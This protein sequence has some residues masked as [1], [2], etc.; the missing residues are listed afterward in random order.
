MVPRMRSILPTQVWPQPNQFLLAIS[1]Y[2]KHNVPEEW[3][4]EC[5]QQQN[6]ILTVSKEDESNLMQVYRRL[7]QKSICAIDAATY[8]VCIVY[9]M[10]L[11]GMVWELVNYLVFWVFKWI[12]KRE[13]WKDTHNDDDDDKRT[14]V[15]QLV[16]HVIRNKMQMATDFIEM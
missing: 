1:M 4:K 8:I 12:T 2:E 5:K 3:A 7:T 11:I 6:T 9:Y 15:K 14:F 13:T 10:N 16:R